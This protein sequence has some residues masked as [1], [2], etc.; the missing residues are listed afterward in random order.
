MAIAK[1]NHFRRGPKKGAQ[2]DNQLPITCAR[3]MQWWVSRGSPV[4]RCGVVMSIG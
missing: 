1:A 2:T 3:S 4:H